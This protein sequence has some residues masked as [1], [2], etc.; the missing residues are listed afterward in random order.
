M[1]CRGARMSGVAVLLL[2]GLWIAGCTGTAEVPESGTTEPPSAQPAPEESQPVPEVPDEPSMDAVAYT[3]LIDGEQYV[4]LKDQVAPGQSYAVHVVCDI[5]TLEYEV[6]APEG[7]VITEE[8]LFT[9]GKVSCPADVM[10]SAFV[11]PTFDDGIKLP[12]D[13]TFQIGLSELDGTN[14]ALVEIVPEPDTEG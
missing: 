4:G 6:R 5:G 9:A 14:N 13:G 2:S 11:V 1:G 8:D 12:N 10:N 3:T 7:G